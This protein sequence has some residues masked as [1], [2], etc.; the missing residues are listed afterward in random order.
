ML[1]WCFIIFGS[2]LWLDNFLQS[3]ARRSHRWT[4]SFV[5]SSIKHALEFPERFDYTSDKGAGQTVVGCIIPRALT[6]WFSRKTCASILRHCF[7]TKLLS[8]LAPFFIVQIMGCLTGMFSEV[9]LVFPVAP[10]QSFRLINV[11]LTMEGSVDPDSLI[12]SAISKKGS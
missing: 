3:R 11:S 10:S 2:K 5:S 7:N 8:P 4:R 6:S 12:A 9:K 1:P